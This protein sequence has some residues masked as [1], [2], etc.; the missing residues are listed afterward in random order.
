MKLGFFAVTALLICGSAVAQDK[1]DT[2]ITVQDGKDM[3]VTGCLAHS[4]EGSYTLTNVANKDGAV[5]SYLLAGS[6]KEDD[7][8]DLDKHVGHRLEITGKAADRGT[9]KLT[10]ETKNDGKKGKTETKSEV[11][12]DLSGLPYLGVKSFRMLASVCP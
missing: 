5:G 8:D 9:G 12:G 6:K 3:T 4:A 2:R 1:S 10:V 7:L 11:K